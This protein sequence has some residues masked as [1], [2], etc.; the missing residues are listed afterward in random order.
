MFQNGKTP[1]V[2]IHVLLL[3]LIG[4]YFA[5]MAVKM[6]GNVRTGSSSM[7]MS[8][9][10]TLA[11]IMGIAGFGVMGYGMYLGY[12]ARKDKEKKDELK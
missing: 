9:T 1:S 6:I 3:A 10:V 2:S 8:T 4:G 5:Y 11:V 12:R 7:A